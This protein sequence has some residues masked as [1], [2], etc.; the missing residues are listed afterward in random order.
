[1]DSLACGV[2]DAFP[3]LSG[4]Q[5]AATG[6]SAMPVPSPET[7]DAVLRHADERLDQSR[8][9]LFSL[10]RIP[11]ISAQ[12]V[13]REDCAR[14]A[15]WVR[16]RLV[17]LGFRTEI[18]PTPGHPVVL[19]HFGGPADYRGPHVLFYGHYDAQPPDPLERWNSPPFEPPLAD[20]PPGKPFV[21]PGA[22]GRQAQRPLLLSA[23]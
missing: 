20:G 15:A 4:G 6:V 7:I 14:A 3:P 19:G 1:M 5:N 13:H 11:S 10:L 22:V 16:D 17:S 18:R 12:E 21:A 23:L 8:E 9:A 2:A